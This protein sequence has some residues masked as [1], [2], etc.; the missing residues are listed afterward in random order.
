MARGD[1]PANR[2][3]DLL[4]RFSISQTDEAFRSGLD[5]PTRSGIDLDPEQ[6]LTLGVR[7]NH[8][9]YSDR[10]KAR[11][12]TESPQPGNIIPKREQRFSP[13]IQGQEEQSSE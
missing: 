13:L 2:K 11:D 3:I 12:K 8:V 6:K 1:L 10:A 5:L 4:V 9:R 7:T